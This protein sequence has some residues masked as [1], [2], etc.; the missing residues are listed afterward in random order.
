MGA[1]LH[2]AVT[3]ECFPDLSVG[4]SPYASRSN[5]AVQQPV[6]HCES[7]ARAQISHP[8]HRYCGRSERQLSWCACHSVHSTC[9]HKSIRSTREPFGPGHEK[10]HSSV[11]DRLLD[12]QS[13]PHCI[14]H[15]S[16]VLWRFN[17]CRGVPR[18]DCTGDRPRWFEERG[19]L[20]CSRIPPRASAAIPFS[21]V[22]RQW[23][24]LKPVAAAGD[25]NRQRPG[26]D[27]RS[28]GP[29]SK[30]IRRAGRK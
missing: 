16:A 19:N 4:P 5:Q 18:C 13:L 23:E 15:N 25:R 29:S 26:S 12:D 21:R 27:A 1:G 24:S 17:F 7:A 2:L 11:G 20:F 3:N 14:E 28:R 8:R 22:K 9:Q 30:R 6:R 10:W